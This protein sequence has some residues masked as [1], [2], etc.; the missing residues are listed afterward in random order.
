M[1][2]QW[3][4]RAVNGLFQGSPAHAH[5][6][7]ANRVKIEENVGDYGCLTSYLLKN[8]RL[9]PGSSNRGYREDIGKIQVISSKKCF[10]E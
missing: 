6:M 3:F 4:R 9:G 2:L 7:T 5:V 10:Q 1:F 8:S